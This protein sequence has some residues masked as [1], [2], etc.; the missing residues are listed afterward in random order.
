MGTVVII[1]ATVDDTRVQ[2]MI[3]IQKA[4]TLEHSPIGTGYAMEVGK[5]G[6]EEIRY[7]LAL[8]GEEV[9]GCIGLSPLDETAGE[10]KTMHVLENWRGQGVS[11]PLLNH[12]LAEARLA[13]LSF[14][15][16]ETGQAKGYDAS[17]RFY[18]K[19]GFEP[20]ERFGRYEGDPES[21]CMS[22]KI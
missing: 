5:P 2:D 12:L 20:C 19:H 7:F 21:Y 15:K 9:V 14:M 13:G 16:L 10:I 6:V 8:V 22:R 3:A 18:S 17:K 4:Y 1:E 11:G